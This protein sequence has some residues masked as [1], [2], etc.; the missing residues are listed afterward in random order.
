MD[1][2]RVELYV[3]RR[4]LQEL[5]FR[6]EAGVYVLG[7]DHTRPAWWSV[8]HEPIGRSVLELYTGRGLQNI[9]AMIE[10]VYPEFYAWLLWTFPIESKA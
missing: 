4:P 10:Q 3:L 7:N 1:L 5:V 9:I 8:R 6:N 2:E